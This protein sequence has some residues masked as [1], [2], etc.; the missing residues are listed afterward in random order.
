MNWDDESLPIFPGYITGEQFLP[1]Y[2]EYKKN[3]IGCNLEITSSPMKT[4]LIRLCC[5]WR[6]LYVYKSLLLL[7][8]TGRTTT[9]VTTPRNIFRIRTIGLWSHQQMARPLQVSRSI[10]GQA[11]V[12]RCSCWSKYAPYLSLYFPCLWVGKSII[13]L[14]VTFTSLT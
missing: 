10:A 12:G 7:F 13:F 3:L 9:R 14:S 4:K 2:D 5:K 6:F 1:I 11:Q 8:I